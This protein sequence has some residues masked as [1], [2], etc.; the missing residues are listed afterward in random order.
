MSF[1]PR[2]MATYCQFP[3][4]IFS[5]SFW[6]VMDEVRSPPCTAKQDMPP[7]VRPVIKAS[8][9]FCITDIVLDLTRYNQPLK[10]DL[11]IPVIRV[12]FIYPLGGDRVYKYG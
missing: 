10:K 6:V 5:L 11:T 3:L 9:K 12:I 2:N 1:A 8:Q 7:V 4:S